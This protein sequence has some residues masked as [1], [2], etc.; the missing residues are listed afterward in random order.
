MWEVIS[1]KFVHAFHE[2]WEKRDVTSRD[3]TPS[4][5]L[6]CRVDKSLC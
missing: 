6:T 5:V 3:V 4:K 1:T 2:V